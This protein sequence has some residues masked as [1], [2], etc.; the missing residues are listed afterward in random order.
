[1]R[2]KRQNV[3][4][5]LKSSMI[6]CA[7]KGISSREALVKMRPYLDTIPQEYIF[8]AGELKKVQEFMRS[9][10]AKAVPDDNGDMVYLLPSQ[11]NERQVNWAIGEYEKM[12]EQA[13][14]GKN[15]LLQRLREIEEEKAKIDRT[16]RSPQMHAFPEEL[17]KQKAE[18]EREQATILAAQN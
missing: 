15:N 8:E 4:R 17:A 13:N 18:L 14:S 10:G 11:M 16:L 5:A 3:P 6:A 12:A 2:Y 9:I 1:M 7:Y